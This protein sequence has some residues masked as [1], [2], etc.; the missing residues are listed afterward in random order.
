MTAEPAQRAQRAL[1]AAHAT[2]LAGGHGAALELLAT[3]ESGPLDE[4]RGAQANLLRAEIAYTERRGR[5]APELLLRAAR[6]LGPTDAGAARD[7]YLDAFVAA[8]FA[9]RLAHGTGTR[10]VAL[11]VRD[12]PGTT[13]TPTASDLLLEGLAAAFLDGFPAGVPV[14]QRAVRAFRDPSVARSDELRW[15]SYSAHAAMS[16]WDED[17]YAFLS[18]RHVELSRQAGLLAALPTALTG[19][20]ISYAL[21]GELTVAEQLVHE[22]LVLTDAMEVPMPP[23]GPL[24]VAAWRGVEAPV[25]RARESAV[26]QV[27]ASGEGAGLA[28]ADYAQAVLCNGLGRYDEA[29]AASVSIDPATEAFVVDGAGRIE[30]V[31]AAVRSGALEQAKL[32]FAQLSHFTSAVGTDWAAGV[33]ARSQALISPDDAAERLY[34]EAIA[35]L[36]RTRIRPQLARAHLVY[37]EWLRRQN[38]RVDARTELRIAYEMLTSMGIEAFA[39]RA[40]H[41]LLATGETVRK[42]TVETMTELTAQEAHIAQLAMD[43]HTNSA[44]A[45]QLFISPRTVEWHLRKVFIKLGIASRRELRSSLVASATPSR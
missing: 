5:D 9:G 33:H 24:V 41:E 32:A 22:L 7:A 8:R 43:D 34:L 15:M 35:S 26:S 13:G 17:S 20:I 31:E 42:R 28:F 14:L 36:A 16:L 10:E 44:I 6:S 45:A 39:E 4:T 18:S 27:S 12:A 2:H 40:R 23:Y 37:G 21:R 38:R 25:T 30:A 19:S 29:L 1:A 11:A 3:A